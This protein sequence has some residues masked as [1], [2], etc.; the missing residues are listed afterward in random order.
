[1]TVV[2]VR[3]WHKADNPTAPAY[4]RFWATADNGRFWLGT[5]CPLMTLSGQNKQNIKTEPV[6]NDPTRTLLPFIAMSAFPPKAEMLRL[7][8]CPVVPDDSLSA[9]A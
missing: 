1:M 5:I 7:T 9:D 4:V 6:A 8:T 3:L 2:D